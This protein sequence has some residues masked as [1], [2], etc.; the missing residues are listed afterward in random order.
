MT[1]VGIPYHRWDYYSYQY[2]VVNAVPEATYVPVKDAFGIIVRML[3]RV[4]SKLQRLTNKQWLLHFNLN[5]Q[6]FDADLNKV[7]IIHLF[8]GVSYG[9]TP[10]A[11][12]FETLVPRFRE[13]LASL[14]AQE[15]NFTPFQ[16]WRFV[17]ALEALA[18]PNCRAVLALSES[19]VKVEQHI[20]TWGPSRLATAIKAKLSVLPPPQPL[21][22]ASYE[23]KPVSL[24]PP[25]HFM[26]VGHDFFR[27]GG[28]EMLEA[29]IAVKQRT[30]AP[31]RLLIVSRLQIDDYATKSTF[32]DLRKAQSLLKAH[33]D[34]IEYTPHL[35]HKETLERMKQAHIGLLPT[36]ADSYGY[37]VLEFMAS[38]CPVVTT[39][40]EALADVNAP[41]RGWIV[42]VPRDPLGSALYQSREGREQVSKAIRAGLEHTLEEILA[43][44]DQIATKGANAIRYIRDVHDPRQH[45]ATLRRIYTG[46]ATD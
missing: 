40:V 18:A 22:V 9:R 35:P 26:F 10:W 13:V 46:E 6:F 39:N 36:Y 8:N 45:A 25:W 24:T 11:T 7:D 5:N 2:N 16:R 15:P 12:T 43:N 17:R 34:W 23:E 33:K 27:K 4:N 29:F 44:P 20:L 14:P 28:L 41:Q 30:H 38:G 19:A 1:H 3:R 37:A 31:I 42:P 32:E 21:H